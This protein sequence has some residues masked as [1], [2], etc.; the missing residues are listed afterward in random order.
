MAVILFTD[1][2]WFVESGRVGG[3]A[4]R[5]VYDGKIYKDSGGADSTTNNRMELRA[6]IEGLDHIVKNNRDDRGITVFSDS[7][8][9][10]NGASIW[11]PQWKRRSWKTGRGNPIKNKDL[12]TDIDFY[13]SEVEFG[14][15]WKWIRGHNGN[16][17]NEAVDLAAYNE[18]TKI[19]RQLGY[20]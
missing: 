11:L 12:W 15:S 8:Y 9:V 18:A 10:I 20:G 19:K 2:S 4:F 7:Q 17:H 14:I 6:V 3:W 1:G 13:I 16:P 5:Y